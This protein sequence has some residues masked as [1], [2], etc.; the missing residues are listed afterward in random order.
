MQRAATMAAAAPGDG[1]TVIQF[2][3]L[4]SRP[5]PCGYC[6]GQG[7]ISQGMFVKRMTVEDYQDLLDR[8]WRRSGRYVYKPLMESTCCPLY[9]I[10]CLAA[11]FCL[12]KSQR[13]VVKKFNT[14]LVEG[15]PLPAKEPSPIKEK[16]SINVNEPAPS[17][18]EV[19]R[20][21]ELANLKRVEGLKK[22]KVLRMEK[23][24]E[25]K[26][27]KAE[28]K[29]DPKVAVNQPKTLAEL[30]PARNFLR[31]NESVEQEVGQ[32]AQHTFSLKM[33]S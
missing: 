27:G 4:S 15:S 7:S 14:F 30:L 1:V 33:V 3:D 22:K 16:L 21:P 13:K 25:K 10:R 32:G 12:S 24:L 26:V 31:L 23:R 9:T 5:G 6:K 19:V 17:P 8:G 11:Q 29:K 18:M 2:L 20:N 28:V